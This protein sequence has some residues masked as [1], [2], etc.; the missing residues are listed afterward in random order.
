VSIRIDAREPFWVRREDFSALATARLTIAA[1]PEPPSI[2]GTIG[3]QRG[4]IELLGQM[5]DVERGTI[6]F[7]GG[8]EVE[9]E[10]DLLA[11]RKAL[12]GNGEKVTIAASGTL[13]APDLRFAIDG[14]PVTAGEAL[15]A[16]LGTR[17]APASDQRV[18]EQVGSVATGIAGSVLTLGA[19]R[20]LGEWVPVLGFAQGGGETR[21]RAGV[22]ADRLIPEF[23]RG[24]VVDA[25]VEGIVS[26]REQT[27]EGQVTQQ[28]ATGAAVLLELR[29]PHSLLSEAQY[30]PGP[31][32]SLDLSWE[33]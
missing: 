18:Q 12:G 13:H 3:V 2:T 5:F 6:R 29:F 24:I 32:W 11:S 33:P 20:E 8:S 10:L 15:A 16:A 28:G 9:P 30:G 26:S 1:V 4:V 19:R 22:E 23:L 31:R 14:K 17:A 7:T 27:D 25:Y 21:I